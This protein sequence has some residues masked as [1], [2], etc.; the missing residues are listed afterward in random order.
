MPMMSLLIILRMTF[1][2]PLKRKRLLA[3]KINLKKRSKLIFRRAF[4]TNSSDPPV[5]LLS[6]KL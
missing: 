4:T 5:A 2:S 6:I 1:N 3:I